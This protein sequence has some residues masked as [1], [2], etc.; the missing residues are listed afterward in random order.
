MNEKKVKKP[1]KQVESWY[2]DRYI[3]VVAQRNFLGLM[4]IISFVSVLVM[5]LVVKTNLE[6]AS[7]EPYVVSISDT[8]KIPLPITI[9]PIKAY[10]DV[11]TGVLEY[12]LAQYVQKREGFNRTTYTFDY[13][14]FVNTMSESGIYRRF[15]SYVISDEGPIKTGAEAEVFIKQIATDAKKQISTLRIASKKTGNGEIKHFK[16]TLHYSFKTE[17]LTYRDMIL[18]PLGIKVDIYEKLE[19]KTLI[20]DETFK[21]VSYT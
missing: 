18:N 3:S 11:N 16:I 14:S 9:E 5:L 1:Q 13:D 21:N 15:R 20:D 2:Q 12:F 17:K 7:V 10:A 6:K 19:E 8:D 4:C